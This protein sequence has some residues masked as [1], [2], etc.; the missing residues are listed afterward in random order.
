MPAL[1][2]YAQNY[3]SVTNAA[4]K[5]DTPDYSENDLLLM[6][7]SVDTNNGPSY[8]SGGEAATIC[9][10]YD[11][12]TGWTSGDMTAAFNSAATADWWFTSASPCAVNDAVYFGHTSPFNSIQV[13]CSTAGAG[14][15]TWVWEYYN[16]ST[17]STLTTLNNGLIIAMSIGIHNLNFNPPANWAS[18]DPGC[19]TAGYYVRCRISAYTSL[20]TRGVYSQGWLGKWNQLC[21]V[22]NGTSAGLGVLYK[23][24]GASEPV[25][26][27]VNDERATNDTKNVLLCSIRDVDT[28]LPFAHATVAALSNAT[29]NYDSDLSLYSGSVIGCA[30][31]F[32][33]P[34]VKYRLA[35]VKFY[36]K[37]L[38]TPTGTITAKLYTQA[39]GIIP[40]TPTLAI[41]NTKNIA[42]DITTDYQLIE[43]TFPWY[44]QYWMNTS[45]VY[46]IGLE[47]SGGDVNNCLKVGYENTTPS[48]AGN[49]STLT[50]AVWTA[51]AWDLIFYAYYFDFSSTTSSAGRFAMPTITTERDNSL[52]LYMGANAA[53]SVPSIIE[54]PCT[55]LVGKDGSAHA[56]ALSWGFQKTAGTSPANVYL[57]ALGTSWTQ[58]GAVCAINPP[59]TGA[60]AIPAYCAS[61]SSVYISPESGAAYLTDAAPVI[62]ATNY[63]GATLNGKTLVSSGT[64]ITYGDTGLN[65]Y[66]A[67]RNV[68]GVITAGSWAGNVSVIASRNLADKNILFHIQPYLPLDIQT[69]D[70]VSLV[71]ACGVAIGFAST[72]NTHY[73][74]WHVGGANTP[75][76]TQRHQPVVI[77]T[78]YTG[79]GKIQD[80]GTLVPSAV[81][82]LGFFVSGK[83]AT[84][85]WLMG[86]IWA[87]DT[88][89]V[90]GG[91]AA[92]PL[93]IPG[94][95]QAAASGHERKSV[96]QQGASQF[97]IFQPLQIGDGGTN[98]VYLNLDTTALEFPKQYDKNTKNVNYC[99]IDNVCGLKYYAGASDTIIHKNSVI[100]SPSRYFWGLHAS[101]NVG[102]TYDF[103][104]LSVIGAGTITLARAITIIG[105]TINDYSTLDI[106]ALI[107]QDSTIK[108]VPAT[109]DSVTTAWNTSVQNSTIDVTNVTA[110]NRWAS[111]ANPE[112]F[113]GCTFIG[114]ASTGHAIRI[115]TP[116]T[117]DLNTLTWTAFGTGNS[118]A[119]FN[120]SGGLVTLNMV[121]GGTVPTIRNGTSASTVINNNVSVDITV[122][123]AAGSNL[124]NA[125]V[126]VEA[127]SGGALPSYVSVTISRSGATAT[128][129]HTAHG[130]STGM[131]AIIRGALQQEYNG[132]HQ[133]TKIGD[134]SY[135]YTVAGT[136][137][138]PATGTITST[139]RIV[140][141]L[142]D[143]TG[144]ASDVLNFTA[145]QPIVGTV[146]SASL[147]TKY[148]PGSISGTIV[149]SG[150]ATTVVLIVDA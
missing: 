55:L 129:V 71:G 136:P 149:S 124:E 25:E 33:S 78:G 84:P 60:T 141:E 6:L 18:A 150:F 72:A 42:T 51:Y 123:N 27:A 95:V 54:G 132:D 115:D 119:I 148:K 21:E 88:T 91:N 49:G 122:K 16:G 108:G 90:A 130:L 109:S 87:L 69:T 131:Y 99:S 40:T 140:N 134:N 26:Y 144:L 82:N 19:G 94:I 80:T 44:Q 58:V 93:Q 3:T 29:T 96:I 113:V 85:D 23:I 31:S 112:I 86:S 56:D 13:L 2:D 1:R 106:S 77:N 146:R 20:T 75:W 142:T 147:T 133:I 145:N 62:T 103:S 139:A 14:A 12:T 8:W 64:T 11:N 121:D 57:T 39:A 30:Q 120:D 76:G 61:D 118:A 125:R 7:C 24:A 81:V 74:V 128:V 53:A 41:S 116:G 97:M 79:A 45:A 37:K 36:L 110:G 38:G 63:F 15:Q 4:Q 47:Y 92:E 65:S 10:L 73:K 101:S 9:W 143:V 43:F 107:L 126:L 104:G 48:H 52:V 135:S 68:N 102:A 22:E 50:G 83:V 59:S 114:S 17:W 32:T 137:V 111:V 127:D 70:S 105:L 66:H 28:A 46:V 34:A 117:Y 5:V 138:T 89:V 35:S 100:S 67:M 98:P